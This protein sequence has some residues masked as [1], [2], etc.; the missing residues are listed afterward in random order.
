MDVHVYL[1]DSEKRVSYEDAGFSIGMSILIDRFHPTTAAPT[2]MNEYFATGDL[3][4][5]QMKPDP[6]GAMVR[7]NIALF[8]AGSFEHVEIKEPSAATPD[9]FKRKSRVH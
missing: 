3:W 6:Q 2:K 4:I 5:F 9:R 1:K 7:N 8:P